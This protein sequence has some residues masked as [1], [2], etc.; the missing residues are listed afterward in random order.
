MEKS[1]NFSDIKDILH[2]IFEKENSILN[3][4]LLLINKNWIKIVGKQLYNHIKPLKIENKILFIRCNHKG[5]INILSFHKET[6][7]KKIN[8]ILNKEALVEIKFI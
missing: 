7:I 3:F 5:W 6:L 4:D 2:N 8:K 1:N